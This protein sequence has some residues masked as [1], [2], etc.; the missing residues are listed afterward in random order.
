M[1]DKKSSLS[2]PETRA[3]LCFTCL[4]CQLSGTEWAW[5]Q[6][7]NT[8]LI[9]FTVKVRKHEQTRSQTWTDLVVT[10]NIPQ[11]FYLSLSSLLYHYHKLSIYCICS[12][13]THALLYYGKKGFFGLL[14][15]FWC[16]AEYLCS[17][18]MV[19]RCKWH[20][21]STESSDKANRYSY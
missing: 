4:L 9:Y 16:L 17:S 13:H 7:G 15:I 6:T 10:L 2:C 12:Y 20:L 18:N 8:D 3:L 21:I 11:A 19:L 5:I 1:I 14:N